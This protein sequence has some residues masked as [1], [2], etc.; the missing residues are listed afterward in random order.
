MKLSKLSALCLA[1]TTTFATTTAM[2][3]E[4]ENGQHMTSASV[5]LASDYVFRGISFSDNKPAISGSFDYEH[6]SGFYTGIWSSSIAGGSEI[7]VYG[8]F[9]SEIGDTGIGYDIGVLRY[10]FPGDSEFNNN[11]VYGALSY[12]YFTLG[13]AYDKNF[14][15][16]GEKVHYWNVAF[17]Y[18]LPIFDGVDFTAAYGYSDFSSKL[19]ISGYSD[20]YVGLS[21][22]F[23]GF[24]WTL[25]YIATSSKAGDFYNEDLGRSATS[26]KFV[27]SI[28]K[29]F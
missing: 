23:V 19:G 3:W 29:T 16:S 18:E 26:D 2:A 14:E 27:F 21:K 8:G 5:E 13:Y 9:A 25:A 6:I 17:D 11:E 12:S 20:Y 10:I 1:A 22:N 15:G 4:S 7:N 28:G 24:D